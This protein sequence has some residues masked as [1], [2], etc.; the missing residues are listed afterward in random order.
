MAIQTPA[1]S[2]VVK[3]P[4]RIRREHI[5]DVDVLAAVIGALERRR[6]LLDRLYSSKPGPAQAE[7]VATAEHVIGECLEALPMPA[8]IA[9]AAA[10][11]AALWR[12][13]SA[14][15]GPGSAE[16]LADACSMRAR[17]IE[18]AVLMGAPAAT[19]TDMIARLEWA[20]ANAADDTFEAWMAEKV[21][22]V[23]LDDLARLLPG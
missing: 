1:T 11:V 2:N 3:L 22:R 4:R 8:T 13:S 23:T 19:I 18:D 12:C 6:A 17:A 7:A 16:L 9:A 21:L 10:E 14:A 5:G 15:S 20:R